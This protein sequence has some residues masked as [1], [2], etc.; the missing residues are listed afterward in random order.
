MAI[1][2]G[3]AG[4]SGS[5]KTTFANSLNSFFGDKSAILYQDNYYKD[6]SSRFDFDGGSVNFDHPDA[7]DF[8]LLI[9]HASN[10]KNGQKIDLPHYDFATHTRLEKTSFFESKEIIFVDGILIFCNSN[11]MSLFDFK[12]F[13]DCEENVRFERRLKRDIEERGRTKDGV[14]AQFNNQ[15]KPMHNLFVE[16]TKKLA[17]DI[18]LEE[19]F[20]KKIL[21]WQQKLSDLITKKE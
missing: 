12:I 19:N 3:I 18:V 8:D 14:I 4:G 21:E 16:P 13:T 15:V 5:G 2:V 10:L 6:Q 1:L 20:N 11:L 7:I 9:N 17:C